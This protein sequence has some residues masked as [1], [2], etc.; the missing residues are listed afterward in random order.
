MKKILF[1]IMFAIIGM[2]ATGQIYIGY[3]AGE[4]KTKLDNLGYKFSNEYYNGQHSISVRFP[5]KKFYTISYEFDENYICS[6][7]FITGEYA[8]ELYEKMKKILYCG[9]DK[10]GSFYC[11]DEDSY[12][13]ELILRRENILNSLHLY[14]IPGILSSVPRKTRETK[15]TRANLF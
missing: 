11:V 4:I 9:Y 8:E 6:S 10:T 13:Y 5:N 1:L 7:I 15:L 12:V 14:I 3:T 2:S